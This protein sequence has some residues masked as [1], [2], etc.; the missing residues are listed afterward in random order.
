MP[1]LGMWYYKARMYSPTLGRFMQTDPIGYSDGMNWY[2]YVGND[3]VNFRDPL[4]LDRAAEDDDKDGNTIVVTGWS[5][6]GIGGGGSSGG[7][8]AF[9]C[10]SNDLLEAEGIVDDVVFGGESPL[11]IIVNAGRKGE[12]NRTAKP[13]GTDNPFKKI[14]SHPSKPGW[15]QYRDQN[16]KTK[17]RPGT[18]DELAHLASKSSPLK[19]GARAVI[20]FPVALIMCVLSP[21]TCGIVDVNG[22]GELGA[23]DWENY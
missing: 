19:D 20:P 15:I 18:P 23:D 16:G 8:V 10:R 22:D 9:C 11:D 17:E 7:G 21:A 14:K 6:I 3:P 12:R 5:A 1:E 4:G 13:S 2:N